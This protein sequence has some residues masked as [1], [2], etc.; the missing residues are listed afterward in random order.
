MVSVKE[1]WHNIASGRSQ[2]QRALLSLMLLISWEIWNERN[3]RVFCS[4][5]V[6]VGVLVTRIK[7]ET[8]LWCFAGA[9][10]LCN[11][12]PRE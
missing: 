9:K 11:I 6:P 7:A 4:M 1:W 5:K 8:S 2:S 10:Y 12:M 3:A